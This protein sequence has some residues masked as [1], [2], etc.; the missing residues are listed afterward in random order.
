LENRLHRLVC[1][2]RLSLRKAQ[3]LLSTNWLAAFIT[4]V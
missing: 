2:G 1:A 3:S 4:Y